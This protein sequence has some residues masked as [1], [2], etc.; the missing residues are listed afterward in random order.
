MLVRRPCHRRAR[1]LNSVWFS[2][3]TRELVSIAGPLYNLP[4]NTALLGATRLAAPDLISIK[5]VDGVKDDVGSLRDAR[6]VLTA[7]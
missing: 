6:R 5:S 2:G 7:G 1:R 3:L 4:P